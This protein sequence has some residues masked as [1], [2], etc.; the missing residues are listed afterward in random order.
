MDGG[1]ARVV[2]IDSK[3][4]QLNRAEA[5][6]HQAMLDGVEPLTRVP[7]VEV[8]YERDGVVETFTD[9]TLPHRAYDGHIRAGTVAGQPATQTPTYQAARNATPANARALMEFSPITLAYGGWDATRKSRQ[10]RW[11][12]A[13]VGEIIGVLADQGLDQRSQ[14]MRGGARVDPVAMRVQLGK[15]AMMAIANDQRSELSAKLYEKIAKAAKTA[16]EKSAAPTSAS[17]LGLGGIPP[18]LEQL[19]GVACT[20]IVRSHVLSLATLRQIRFGASPEGDASCRALLAALAL[21]G[22]A[23]SDAELCIR[24]NCDLVEA[25]ATKVTIDRRGGSAETLEPLVVTAADELLRAAIAAA[26]RDAGIQWRGQVFAVDGDP[27]VI[28]SADDSADEV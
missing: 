17:T 5:A 15:A 24:A 2:V 1:A 25:G 18:T 8:R 19:A 14:P 3:Q 20:R 26:E 7:R 28:A 22:L 9:F 11:R 12:S 10:G 21:D 27:D 13:L 6:L 4:S 16:D 23:R